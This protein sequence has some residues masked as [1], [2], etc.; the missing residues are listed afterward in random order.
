MPHLSW[1]VR[2]PGKVVLLRAKEMRQKTFG[3]SIFSKADRKF[4]SFFRR[5]FKIF[6]LQTVLCRECVTCMKSFH[7][8]FQMPT[9]NGSW[10]MAIKAEA[11]V[12]GQMAAIL[13]LH[14]LSR[15]ATVHHNQTL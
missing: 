15:S 12:N 3:H 2:R 6:N 8:K 11:K 9:E 4:S 1:L 5:D 14:T 7:A 13:L 10:F